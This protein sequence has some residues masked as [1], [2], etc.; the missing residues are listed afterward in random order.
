MDA[1]A[2]SSGAEHA[3]AEQIVSTAA[4]G[5]INFSGAACY[6]NS[7]LQILHSSLHFR[8]F[9]LN[10]PTTGMDCLSRLKFL[11][12][13]LSRAAKRQDTAA[14]AV[15]GH[16]LVQQFIADESNTLRPGKQEDAHEFLLVLLKGLTDSCTS[17]QQGGRPALSV[18][19]KVWY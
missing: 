2:I 16:A 8:H 4:V 14:T 10:Y 7:I 12:E 5:L 11:F 15:S 9:I 18:S 6:A 19:C 13:S 1:V 3:A 17:R